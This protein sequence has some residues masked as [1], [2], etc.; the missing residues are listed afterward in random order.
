M[1]DDPGAYAAQRF[2]C[3]KLKA[4]LSYGACAKR[5]VRRTLSRWFGKETDSLATPLDRVCWECPVGR[6]RHERLSKEA[7][8]L[9]RRT[10]CK[11]PV[12]ARAL[13]EVSGNLLAAVEWL[14]HGAARPRTLPP[15]DDRG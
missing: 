1:S 10:G 15:H 7:A 6:L 2:R 14:R 9:R 5:Y 13:V 8:E 11:P 12:C 4:T 3:P